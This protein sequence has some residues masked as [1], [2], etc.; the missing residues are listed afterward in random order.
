MEGTRKRGRLL[1]TRRDEAEEYLTIIGT[2][3]RQAMIR[4]RWEW[5]KTAL[6]A[7]VHNGLQCLRRRIKFLGLA[8]PNIQ[9]E[10]NPLGPELNGGYTLQKLGI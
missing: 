7:K 6:E 3:N 1:K 8:Y 4:H 5:R 9:C 2:K 10:I